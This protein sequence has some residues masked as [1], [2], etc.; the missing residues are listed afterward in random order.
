[1]RPNK[2]KLIGCQLRKNPSNNIKRFSFRWMI[3][4]QD[5]KLA[6]VCWPK[7]RPLSIKDVLESWE[8][9]CISV[10]CPN[11]DFYWPK[12]DHF[13]SNDID[14]ETILVNGSRL[15]GII[16]LIV[17]K[18]RLSWFRGKRLGKYIGCIGIYKIYVSDLDVPLP[19]LGI[20]LDPID[21]RDL[22]S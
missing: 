1:M 15:T 3:L 2:D 17:Q 7:S 12:S 21:L 5:P 10:S 8:F 22:P 4:S 9:C 14:Y 16:K 19:D 6:L 20:G 18:P 13:L 11:R